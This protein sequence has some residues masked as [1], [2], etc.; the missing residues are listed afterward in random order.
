[1]YLLK[2]Q[3]AHLYNEDNNTYLTITS[4][5]EGELLL[6]LSNTTAPSTELSPAQVLNKLRQWLIVLSS[7]MRNDL[8]DK[9]K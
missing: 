3:I 9:E 5:S 8:S 2:P 4:Q 1:M 6:S 7:P